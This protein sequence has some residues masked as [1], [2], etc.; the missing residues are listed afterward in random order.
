MP[1]VAELGAPGAANGEAH[2]VAFYELQNNLDVK[3]DA[4]RTGKILPE[5][6]IKVVYVKVKWATIDDYNAWLLYKRY[7]TQENE[8][9]EVVEIKKPLYKKI[10]FDGA[11]GKKM[12][13]QIQVGVE[14]RYAFKPQ[15]N[16]YTLIS[17]EW[18]KSEKDRLWNESHADEIASKVRTAKIVKESDTTSWWITWKDDLSHTPIVYD[19]FSNIDVSRLIEYSKKSVS[20]QELLCF[21]KQDADFW[22]VHVMGSKDA[23]N[24]RPRKKGHLSK[25]RLKHYGTES[26][27][28]SYSMAGDINFSIAGALG[29]SIWPII[30]KMENPIMGDVPNLID[31]IESAYGIQIKEV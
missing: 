17:L 5:D 13:T 24:D 15:D 14:P 12:S 18:E 11:D 1:T 22:R 20:A 9:K 6:A 28:G 8:A 27:E 2:N 31:A 25:L 21:S 4:L 19:I 26:T 10:T 23:F 29:Y 16:T 3:A 7:P 30:E